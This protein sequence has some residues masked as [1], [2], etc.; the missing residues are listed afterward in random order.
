MIHEWFVSFGWIAAL[1]FFVP[2]FATRTILKKT[3]PNP[4]TDERGGRVVG[5]FFFG[6]IG[7]LAW[8]VGFVCLLAGWPAAI[9]GWIGCAMFGLAIG[10]ATGSV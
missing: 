4:N 10:S 3:N 8:V 1:L 9:A 2:L 7:V 5:L 6:A